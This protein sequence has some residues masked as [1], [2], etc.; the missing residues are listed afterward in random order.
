MP[1]WIAPGYDFLSSSSTLP[2]DLFRDCMM[3]PDDIS[4]TMASRP[5]D[6]SSLGPLL[7]RTVTSWNGKLSKTL[8]HL[9]SPNSHP[10]HNSL[11]FSSFP[12]THFY[13][14][15]VPLC[16]A[17]VWEGYW[18]PPRAGSS[19]LYGLWA[20]SHKVLWETAR[21]ASSQLVCGCFMLQWWS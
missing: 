11:S 7:C 1:P 12:P 14:Y 21:P 15:Y 19:R 4:S 2:I 20:R 3:H 16:G 17:I 8:S 6:P 9:N 18:G 5:R 13:L 10:D